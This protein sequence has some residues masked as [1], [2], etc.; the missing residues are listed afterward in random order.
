LAEEL[1][2]IVED[3]ET[4]P[5]IGKSVDDMVMDIRAHNSYQVNPDE[6]DQ[7]GGSNQTSKKA[8]KLQTTPTQGQDTAPIPSPPPQGMLTKYSHKQRQRYLRKRIAHLIYITI[9]NV[10]VI[11]V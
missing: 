3:F 5:G 8:K 6:K 11:T 7:Q 1:E 9:I 4:I 2:D 10:L